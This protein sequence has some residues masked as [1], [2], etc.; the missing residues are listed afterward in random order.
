MTPGLASILA[1]PAPSAGCLDER[2]LADLQ[3]VF[4]PD[5]MAEFIALFRTSTAERIGSLSASLAESDWAR[6]AADLHAI[7]GVAGT[8]GASALG[9]AAQELQAACKAQANPA[10]LRE[11]AHRLKELAEAADRD[12]EGW[13]PARPIRAA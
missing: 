13:V 8:V 4:G 12:L 6:L 7:A 2:A 5:Q 1:L 11:L 3:S 9:R 10:V